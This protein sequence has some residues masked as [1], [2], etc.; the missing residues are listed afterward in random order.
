MIHL[1]QLALL[2]WRRSGFHSDKLVTLSEACNKC[3][4][5]FT[6]KRYHLYT[7]QRSTH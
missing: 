5:E 7:E 4:N 6:R 3:K 1:I 2:R